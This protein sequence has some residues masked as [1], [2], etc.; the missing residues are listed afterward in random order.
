MTYSEKLKDPRWQKKRLEIIERDNGCCRFCGDPTQPLSVH[1][2]KY[3]GEPWEVENEHL[4]TTCNKC[5]KREHSELIFFSS[6]FEKE[7]NGEGSSAYKSLYYILENIKKLDI[8]VASF[9]KIIESCTNLDHKT[10][11]KIV[12]IYIDNI[13]NLSKRKGLN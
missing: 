10:F 8:P 1:H 13:K 4:A 7:M 5:H 11:E 2:F 6:L 12:D 3:K 9:F